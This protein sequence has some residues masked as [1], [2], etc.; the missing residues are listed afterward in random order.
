LLSG[1]AA[2]LR[3]VWLSCCRLQSRSEWLLRWALALR[4][5]WRLALQSWWLGASLSGA[6]SRS[7]LA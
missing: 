3:W 1:S 5:Q 6:A 7:V 2:A 4:S